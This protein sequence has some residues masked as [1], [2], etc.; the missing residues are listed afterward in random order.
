MQANT[1]VMPKN[2]TY[3]VLFL[4][5]PVLYMLIQLYGNFGGLAYYHSE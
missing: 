5:E 2:P 4:F 3:N 1:T